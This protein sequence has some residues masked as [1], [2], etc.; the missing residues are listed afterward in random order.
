MK[1]F[2]QL[3]AVLRAKTPDVA[4]IERAIADAEAA[5][6]AAV[7]ELDRLQGQ[8]AGMLTAS[9]P[10]RAAHEAALA[11]AADR[12]EDAALLVEQ[13]RAR[14]AEAVAEQE[15]SRRRAIY[16]DAEARVRDARAALVS[17]YPRIGPQLRILA[18]AVAEAD[19]AAATANEAL[20]NEAPPLSP[21]ETVR[22]VGA[23]APAVLR[24]IEVDPWCYDIS[25]ERLPSDL[26]S[27]VHGSGST[28][29]LQPQGAYGGSSIPVSRR[30]FRRIERRPATGALSGD[31]MANPALPALRADQ[32]A[33]LGPR[34]PPS[35]APPA[36]EI[37]PATEVVFEPV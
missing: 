35:A 19:A 2:D 21:V 28:G 33:F 1:I 16:V 34:Q 9:A 10:Q 32:P 13:L 20:P 3:R 5:S 25:G 30:R 17:E 18:V 29:V 11:E 8:R 27:L 36:V 15:Q 4:A 23:A 31:R 14:H 37:Q 6:A 7:V 24:E 22:S 26:Q 12:A